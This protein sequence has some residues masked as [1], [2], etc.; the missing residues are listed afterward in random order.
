MKGKKCSG[1]I[2]CAVITWVIIMIIVQTIGLTALFFYVLKKIIPSTEDSAISA[3]GSLVSLCGSLIFSSIFSIVC[4]GLLCYFC[5]EMI[6]V[7]RAIR[8]FIKRFK[9]KK[10]WFELVSDD[11]DSDDDVATVYED[12]SLSQS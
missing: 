8:T 4:C 6:K 5:N 7:Y 12:N 2:K 11:S 1:I 3:A 9:W 10:Y